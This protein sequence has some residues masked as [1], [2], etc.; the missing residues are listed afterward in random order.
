ME[1]QQAKGERTEDT[2]SLP[3]WLE[4]VDHAGRGA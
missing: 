1:D 2:V 4:L 3:I